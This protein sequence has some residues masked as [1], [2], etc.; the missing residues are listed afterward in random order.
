VI[1]YEGDSMSREFMTIDE[2]MQQLG[3]ERREVERM[4]SRGRIPGRRVAG[5]WRF[6]R[7]EITQWLETEIRDFDDRDLARVEQTQQSADLNPRS[8]LSQL[9]CPETVQVPLD[10]GTKPSTLQ[11][12]VEVAGRTWQILEPAAVLEAVKQREETMSTGFDNGVAIPH[13]R[14]PLPEALSDSVVAFGRTLSGIPFGGPK[15]SLTDMFFLVL[16]RDSRTHLQILARIGRL[17]QLPEFLDNLR[18]AETS[19]D[20]YTVICEADASID[21]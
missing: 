5:E 12:L 9:I 16:A 8:P 17:I 11:S 10:A 3:R 18:A 21:I 1:L 4:V 14:N 7:M 20:A 15:R 13:P 2:L 6:N 19:A